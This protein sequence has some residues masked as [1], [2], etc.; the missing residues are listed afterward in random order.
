MQNVRR[1][2]KE[3]LTR[4]GFNPTRRCQLTRKCQNL[5]IRIPGL[6][7]VFPNVGHRD[8][9]HAAIIFLH[10][11]LVELFQ[12]IHF[13]RKTR[14]RTT[15]DQRLLLL[16]TSGALRNQRTERSCRVQ[17]SFFNDSN[18]TATDRAGVLFLLPHVLGHDASVI[19]ADLRVPVLTAVAV[20]QQILIA[21]SG[22]RPYTLSELKRI[23]DEGYVLC[24]F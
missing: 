24:V 22:A 8:R 15:I 23:F 6:D 11:T 12:E 4:Y 13:V 7:E 1:L 9:M 17:E 10:R 18:M 16:S 19:P 3:R 5:L 20:A 14:D 21:L 2:A